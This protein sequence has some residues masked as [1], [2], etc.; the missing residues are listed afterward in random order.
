MYFKFMSVLKKN[1]WFVFFLLL[2]TGKAAFA[3]SKELLEISRNNRFY[4]GTLFGYGRTTWGYLVAKDPEFWF[5][6][7]TNVQEGG[8]AFGL[9]MGYEISPYFAFEGLYVRFPSATIKFHEGSEYDSENHIDHITSHSEAIS[10]SGKFLAPIANTKL[11]GYGLVGVGLAHRSD[12][13]AKTHNLFAPVFGGG[14]NYSYNEHFMTELGF[15]YYSGLA[16]SEA[17]VVDDF[18]PFLYTFHITFIYRV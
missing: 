12:A 15:N 4:L 16:L 9:L 3:T 11:R 10:L 13:L 8:F 1:V 2:L 14:L 17:R 6:T 7:P 18:M 5:S